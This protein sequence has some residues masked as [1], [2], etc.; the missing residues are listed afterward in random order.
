M[1]IL[2]DNFYREWTELDAIS[3]VELVLEL[4]PME[5][6]S[7]EEGLHQIHKHKDSNCECEEDIVAEE[8]LNKVR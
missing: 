6:Q 7:V 2:K 4:Y 5:S 3:F 8:Q 1:R